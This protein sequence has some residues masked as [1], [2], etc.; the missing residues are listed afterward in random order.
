MRLLDGLSSEG[1]RRVRADRLPASDGLENG[2]SSTADP[3]FFGKM[4]N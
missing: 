3:T 1:V 4:A 2:L